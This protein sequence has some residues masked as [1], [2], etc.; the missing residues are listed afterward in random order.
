MMNYDRGAEEQRGVKCR[1]LGERESAKKLNGQTNPP[2]R[3]PKATIK[4]GPVLRLL[5]DGAER[6][7]KSGIRISECG[8]NSQSRERKRP[9]TSH[10]PRTTNH[11][12][13][14]TNHELR[15]RLWKG[16]IRRRRRRT[17]R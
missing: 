6:E 8:F 17:W 5:A 4:L 15:D 12:S 3:K 1:M 13:R 9:V 11:E 14:I 7:R 10:E 16:A 2:R